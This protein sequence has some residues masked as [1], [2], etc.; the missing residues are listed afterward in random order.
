MWQ[1]IVENH[2]FEAHFGSE[3]STGLKSG[4]PLDGS[5]PHIV[6]EISTSHRSSVSGTLTQNDCSSSITTKR[7]GTLHAKAI[8]NCVSLLEGTETS[9]PEILLWKNCQAMRRLTIFGSWGMLWNWHSFY[10]PGRR[11]S[12]L[13]LLPNTAFG[14]TKSAL[15]WF[16]SL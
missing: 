5:S 16:L 8:A 12:L 15:Q 2:P 13:A 3:L 10:E 1:T 7:R 11:P 14:Y 6:H 4:Q 9:F